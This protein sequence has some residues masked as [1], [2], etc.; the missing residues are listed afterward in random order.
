MPRTIRDID[1]HVSARLGFRR[2]ELGITQ[3]ALANKLGLS[4]QQVQKY[5][6]GTNRISAGILYELSEALAVPVGFFFEGAE[7]SRAVG[8]KRRGRPG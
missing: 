4:F 6:K 7:E 1:S 2:K 5:E 8:R 3:S